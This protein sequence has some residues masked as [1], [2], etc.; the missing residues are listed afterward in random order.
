[1]YRKR[2]RDAYIHTCRHTH[3]QS[4]VSLYQISLPKYWSA[5]SYTRRHLFYGY[6]QVTTPSHIVTKEIL[7]SLPPHI[8][9]D[10]VYFHCSL[11]VYFS[12]FSLI[13]ISHHHF[14]TIF[15]FK[16]KPH[17]GAVKSCNAQ[18]HHSK[19]SIITKSNLCPTI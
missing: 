19:L 9:T 11:I 12:Y 6:I 17:L 8:H 4:P 3:T 5:K 14:F 13:S 2:E 1:M 15:S 10:I 7:N 16:D 18:H